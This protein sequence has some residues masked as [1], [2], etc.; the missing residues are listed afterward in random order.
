MAYTSRNTSSSLPQGF[1]IYQPALGAQ[2][3]FLPAIGTPELDELINAYVAGPAS[4][5]EKRA[6][7]SL[8]FLEYAH[9]TGQTF[10]FYPVYSMN[11]AVE[12]PTT[13][14]GY[15]SSF[16]VSPVTSSWDFSQISTSQ[17]PPSQQ[18]RKS[19]KSAPSRHQTMDFGSLPGMKIMTKD[20]RD[21]T[22]SASRGSKTK[23]QRDHAH[24]MR[25]IKACDTC[26]R[27]KVR[28]DPSHKKPQSVA[29]SARKV[30][31]VAQAVHAATTSTSPPPRIHASASA[32]S[33]TV[34]QTFATIDLEGLA[35]SLSSLEPWEEFIDYPSA[36]EVDVNADYDFFNDPA[37]YFSPESA[38]SSSASSC[39]TKA[40]TPTS[41]QDVSLHHRHP[42]GESGLESPLLPFEQTESIHNYVDFNLF[43]PD[44]SFSEDEL[45]V[46]IDLSQHLNTTY[47]RSSQS[48]SPRSD[49]SSEGTIASSGLTGP[50][51]EATSWSVSSSRRQSGEDESSS[52]YD[53]GSNGGGD[54]HS[55]SSP[56]PGLSPD[57]SSQH[58][59]SLESLESLLESYD[60]LNTLQDTNYTI[61]SR[62]MAVAG[63]DELSIRRG[64]ITHATA[65]ANS[66][67]RTRYSETESTIAIAESTIADGAAAYGDVLPSDTSV[68][69]RPR[70]QASQSSPDEQDISVHDY[71]VIA[72]E[73]SSQRQMSQNTAIATTNRAVI[74]TPAVIAVEASTST[75]LDASEDVIATIATRAPRDESTSENRIASSG[76]A[77][78]S[79]QVI[80]DGNVVAPRSEPQQPPLCHAPCAVTNGGVDTQQSASATTTTT[81]TTMTP[82]T[83]T[84]VQAYVESYLTTMIPTGIALVALGAL[85]SHL[86]DGKTT[87][88]AEADK[89]KKTAD[90]KRAQ[91]PKDTV[92]LGAKPVTHM[93]SHHSNLIAV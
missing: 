14:S 83:T 17:S 73:A 3:Q 32:S 30:K 22:N 90:F 13:D 16:N 31:A 10:K 39:S 23:E 1:S 84:S 54:Y 46:P 2:L 57:L 18:A 56:T 45:M 65:I 63:E 26:K 19:P 68:K 44:S 91:A 20:G 42:G 38:S 92:L 88:F 21:V 37:G 76:N 29:K 25:I 11:A 71:V 36:A 60:G 53:P 82:A 81:T 52:Y 33:I 59:D 72:T 85:F 12:S 61:A 43:S 7:V 80:P 15:G 86:F 48:T 74:S 34:D 69:Y 50:I 78:Q 40:I 70:P 35:P 93:I 8:D 87:R 77:T 66:N 9:V 67:L 51:S 5:Q 89:T 55:P 27:K 24:L 62:S 58:R 64:S 41:E 6:S 75:Q 4:T 49:L 47:S 28:C 79:L